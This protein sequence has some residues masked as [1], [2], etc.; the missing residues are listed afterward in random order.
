MPASEARNSESVKIYYG[1]NIRTEHLLL[2]SRIRGQE[3]ARQFATVRKLTLGLSF[4][5][6]RVVMDRQR[7][8]YH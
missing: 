6:R 4:F 3:E 7:L 5:L 8:D 2:P 1:P